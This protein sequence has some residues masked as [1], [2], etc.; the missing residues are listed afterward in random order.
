MTDSV[1]T[2]ED[3]LGRPKPG[4]KDGKSNP[5][6]VSLLHKLLH[7]T[8]WKHLQSVSRVCK[9]YNNTVGP[10]L[11][12]ELWTEQ[13]LCLWVESNRVLTQQL[14]FGCSPLLLMKTAQS[15]GSCAAKVWYYERV[16]SN[17]IRSE[18]IHIFTPTSFQ[19]P[20][21]I[22]LFFHPADICCVLVNRL[23]PASCSL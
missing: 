13:Q 15:S 12:E 2:W 6:R 7:F 20:C 16:Y 4:V 19:E 3:K 17:T 21:V 23:H 5:S 22:V 8:S 1:V 11:H 10:D 9:R 18:W 14:V